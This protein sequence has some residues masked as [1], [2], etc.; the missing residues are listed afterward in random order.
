MAQTDYRTLKHFRLLYPEN[1]KKYPTFSRGTRI[2]LFYPNTDFFTTVKEHPFICIVPPE[3]DTMVTWVGESHYFRQNGYYSNEDKMAEA[4]VTPFEQ[5]LDLFMFM[6]VVVEERPE[7]SQLVIEE[8]F[9]SRT[10][11]EYWIKQNTFHKTTIFREFGIGTRL[12]EAIPD[13]HNYFDRNTI[14]TCGMAD[15]D[16]Q[17]IWY[18]KHEDNYAVPFV[19]NHYFRLYFEIDT[20][21]A[22]PDWDAS[23]YD[24][25]LEDT[26]TGYDTFPFT[27]ESKSFSVIDTLLFPNSISLNELVR[28]NQ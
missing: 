26:E 25:T 19:L 22:M 11:L 17:L 5:L 23:H 3:F 8:C 13:A 10:I 7:D 9:D 14:C 1:L 27:F 28:T 15:C 18:I 24:E 6:K 2:E 16:N 4:T 21:N 12:F 20:K